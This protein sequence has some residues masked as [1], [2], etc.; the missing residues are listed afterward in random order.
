MYQML[1]ANDMFGRSPLFFLP[2]GRS[3]AHFTSM[4]DAHDRYLH[5]QWLKGIAGAFAGAAAFALLLS[6]GNIRPLDATM[7]MERLADK[8]ERAQTIKPEAAAEIVR[9]TRQPWYDC[10]KVACGP[11]LAA[12]NGQARMRLDAAVAQKTSIEVAAQPA[13]DRSHQ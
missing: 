12:R 8:V 6:A 5:R 13:G 3:P 9:V 11:Q 7:Q 2:S 1:G 4:R 10:A